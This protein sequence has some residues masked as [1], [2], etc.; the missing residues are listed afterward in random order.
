MDKIP[1]YGNDLYMDFRY[2]YLSDTMSAL[3]NLIDSFKKKNREED[4][5]DGFFFLEDSEQTY[6]LALIAMQ[7]YIYGSINDHLIALKGEKKIAENLYE[8]LIKDKRKLKKYIW[9]NYATQ[10]QINKI[11]NLDRI[12]LIISLSNYYKHRDEIVGL[13]SNTLNVLKK[14]DKKFN[15][16]EFEIDNSPII[17]GIEL[18]SKNWD[19][20]EIVENV[21]IWREK[22]WDSDGHPKP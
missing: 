8:K 10:S 20:M 4:Y 14:L 7:N 18:L 12:E 6:G 15:E 13:D 9:K 1:F 16:E 5:Y 21:K 11:N 2:N 22:L 3:E 17:I 19:L